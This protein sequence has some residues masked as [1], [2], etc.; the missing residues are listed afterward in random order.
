LL[1][2]PK[3]ADQSLQNKINRSIIFHYLLEKKTASR[4]EI[5]K[6]LKIS[7][8][9]VSRVIDS[10][11]KENYVVEAEKIKTT[12]GKRPIQL[13]IN[14]RKG[15]ILGIDL[16]QER[17]QASLFDFTG[18]LLKKYRG[19]KIRGKKDEAIKLIRE[20]R[21]FLDLCV[22][23][24]GTSMDECSL[25][26]ISVGV[27]ADIDVD[28]GKILS[29]SLYD[30]WN[31]INFKELLSR[32][33]NLPVFVEKDVTLSVLAEK[34][35]GQG[36]DYSDV[37]FI[38]ISS[39]VSAGIIVNNHLVRGFTGSAGQIAF[40]VIDFEKTG[41]INGNKGYLDLYASIPSIKERAVDAIQR[42]KKSNLLDMVEN[43]PE[44][45]DPVLVCRAAL[46]G[47]RLCND[48]I[49]EVVKLL[50]IG[51]INLILIINPQVIV[52]GGTIAN[53]PD[54]ETLFIERITTIIKKAVPF[55]IPEFKISS[56]G[57]DVVL[58]GASHMAVEALIGGEFPYKI[59]I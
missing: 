17:M 38:E 40:S 36:R 29:A 18:R 6:Q 24:Y 1:E 43:N 31:Q 56:L 52:L 33:F 22:R 19:F 16:S 58:I 30:D 51:M 20:I 5:A 2:V 27:P 8:S 41:F 50:S 3:T 4:A 44:R 39:G 32:E 46:N 7:A 28:S 14:S 9:A 59:G 48:I 42:G 13:K 25:Q 57:E 47:D 15:S 53:L 26:S 21:S 23:E 12:V 55:R 34:N 35:H 49:D 54:V 10:L 11:I 45:I 37:I